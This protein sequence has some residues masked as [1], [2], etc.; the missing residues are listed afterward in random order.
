MAGPLNVPEGMLYDYTT[1]TLIPARPVVIVEPPP[2]P[3]L[4]VG[5][6]VQLN[7]G[8]PPMT[9]TQVDPDGEIA[10]SWFNGAQEECG[11][12][13]RQCLRTPMILPPGAW[14]EGNP[15]KS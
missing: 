1:G 13:P 4:K 7:S 8:G 9:V 3:A 6:I 5:D 14:V 11:T 12:F 10:V 2:A 15:Y